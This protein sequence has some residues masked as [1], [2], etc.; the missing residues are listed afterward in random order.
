MC[1]TTTFYTGEEE[2]PNYPLIF[3]IS[4]FEKLC[5]P[6]YCKIFLVFFHQKNSL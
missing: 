2:I 1:F 6:E 4:F 3:R 5:I